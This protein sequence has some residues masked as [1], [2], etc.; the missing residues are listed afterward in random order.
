MKSLHINEVLEAKIAIRTK[1][2]WGC[3]ALISSLDVQTSNKPP[4]SLQ[5]RNHRINLLPVPAHTITSQRKPRHLPL[6]YPSCNSTLHHNLENHTYTFLRI[7]FLRPIQ[8]S[9]I[10]QRI[11]GRYVLIGRMHSGT[12]GLERDQEL[13]AEGARLDNQDT[14]SEGGDLASEAFGHT[15]LVYA[16]M[17][18]ASKTNI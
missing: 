8:A 6:P 18:V 2:G 3:V 16:L 17:L 13:S 9:Q 12:W 1:V 7:P 5:I 10:F 14:N 11:A 15:C 4:H